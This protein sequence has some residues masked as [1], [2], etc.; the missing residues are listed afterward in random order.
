VN[1]WTGLTYRCNG[2]GLEEESEHGPVALQLRSVAEHV[3]FFGVIVA[4]YDMA[5]FLSGAGR[6]G[7]VYDLLL[8]RG[9]H[10]WKWT[11]DSGRR[12]Y[13]VQVE[14]KRWKPTWTSFQQ[15][16]VCECIKPH[17]PKGASAV[18]DKNGS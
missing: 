3:Q 1:R 7:V 17:T 18:W 11:A 4:Q 5:G 2:Q 13:R 15:K 6:R 8:L 10:S 14:M 9:C 12:V 16:T